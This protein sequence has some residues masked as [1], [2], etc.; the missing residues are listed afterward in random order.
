MGK[1]YRGPSTLRPGPLP[2]KPPNEER[3]FF[4]LIG[5]LIWFIVIHQL[6]NR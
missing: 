1:A 6:F 5:K 4:G 3:V 2:P